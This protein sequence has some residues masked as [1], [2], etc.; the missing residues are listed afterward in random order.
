[1]KNLIKL[2]LII[3]VFVQCSPKQ[4]LNLPHF[5]KLP[6]FT[7]TNQNNRPVSSKDLLGKVYFAS[8][9]FTN[10]AMSCPKTMA[11][12]SLLQ[13]RIEKK[14]L[15]STLMVTLTVDPETDTPARLKEKAV[16]Y[17]ARDNR[18]MFLTGSLADIENLVLNG[19]KTAMSKVINNLGDTIDVAHSDK[20]VLV[21]KKG[22]V[23]GFFGRESNDEMDKLLNALEVLSLEN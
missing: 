14:A 2:A 5:Y 23:R 9:V 16:E 12:L 3:L 22:W 17:H 15:K 8:F 1:M 18:W 21:D 19:F 20:F 6:E 13:E 10:C 4:E 7:L 11:A